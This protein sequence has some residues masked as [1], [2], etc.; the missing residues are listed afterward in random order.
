VAPPR[1]VLRQAPVASNTSALLYP[2]WQPVARH[3]HGGAPPHAEDVPG[4]LFSYRPREGA[5]HPRISYG[6][7]GLFPD[8]L[9]GHRRRHRDLVGP[10]GPGSDEPGHSAAKGMWRYS[11]GGKRYLQVTCRNGH[12]RVQEGWFGDRVRHATSPGQ[13]AVVPQPQVARVPRRRVRPQAEGDGHSS[14][15]AGSAEA[16]RTPRRLPPKH[17]DSV[18]SPLDR[19]EPVARAKGTECA[20]GAPSCASLRDVPPRPDLDHGPSP[21]LRTRTVTRPSHSVRSSRSWKRAAERRAAGSVGWC[22]QSRD[23]Q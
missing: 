17:D 12:R 21:G 16:P 2:A 8:R 7:H 20:Q 6:N 1:V 23:E 13:Q 22:K 18:R 19:R 14:V 9:P 3:P 15:V 4:G 11:D 10:H 5:H